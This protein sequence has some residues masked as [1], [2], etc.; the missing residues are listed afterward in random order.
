MV[1]KTIESNVYIFSETKNK[2]TAEGIIVDITD[3]KNIER[4]INIKMNLKIIKS[5]SFSNFQKIIPV[6]SQ[7]SNILS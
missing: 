3:Q 7:M 2:N 6:F 4:K 1:A 5:V